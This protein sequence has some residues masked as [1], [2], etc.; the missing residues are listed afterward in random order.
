MSDTPQRIQTQVRLPVTPEMDRATLVQQYHELQDELLGAHEQYVALKERFEG[1]QRRISELQHEK[2][3]LI[4]EHEALLKA[5][6]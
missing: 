5:S 1:A 6:T 4:L 2:I 3:G